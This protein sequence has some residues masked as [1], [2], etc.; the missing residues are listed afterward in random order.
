MFFNFV[1]SNCRFWRWPEAGAFF[2]FVLFLVCFLLFDY[3]E[4]SQ[5]LWAEHLRCGFALRFAISFGLLSCFYS[6]WPPFSST[7]YIGI[8][9]SARLVKL[10]KLPPVH[11]TLLVSFS[12]A[13]VFK[14]ERFPSLCF[15]DAF[16]ILSSDP[17]FCIISTLSFILRQ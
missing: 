16:N 11:R 1:P 12:S 9:G 7:G 6:I 8:C 13:D 2:Y 5:I 4:W 17:C 10:C 15:L 3:G 14:V